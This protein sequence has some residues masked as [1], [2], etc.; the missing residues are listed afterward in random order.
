MHARLDKNKNTKKRLFQRLSPDLQLNRTPQGSRRCQGGGEGRSLYAK[1]DNDLKLLR[2]PTAAVLGEVFREGKDS[3]GSPTACFML[4][5]PSI[6]QTVL[7]N[8]LT[9]V[10]FLPCTPQPPHK[11]NIYLELPTILLSAFKHCNPLLANRLLSHLLLL[12]YLNDSS[13]LFSLSFSSTSFSHLFL[14]L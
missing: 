5:A 14:L 9:C 6:P 3:P 12:F 11:D 10:S 8:C 4:T 7:A 13:F 1:I 2:R